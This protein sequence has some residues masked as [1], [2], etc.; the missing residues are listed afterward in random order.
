MLRL[1]SRKSSRTG[2]G[3]TR[4]VNEL[5]L[6]PPV[7]IAACTC[8]GATSC[9]MERDQALS[10]RETLWPLS[11]FEELINCLTLGVLTSDIGCHAREEAR[12]SFKD[13]DSG[14]LFPDKIRDCTHLQPSDRFRVHVGPRFGKT[15][16]QLR[17]ASG[18]LFPQMPIRSPRVLRASTIMVAFATKRLIIPA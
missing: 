17:L 11:G 13:W 14:K 15:C 8:F 2:C 16:Q 3:G 7:V 18:Q 1:T 12:C 10:S 6:Q 5:S 4:P 9:G